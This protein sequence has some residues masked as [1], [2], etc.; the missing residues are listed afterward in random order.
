MFFGEFNYRKKCF[1]V[2][3]IFLWKG[4]GKI[5]SQKFTQDYSKNAKEATMIYLSNH[6]EDFDEVKWKRL[7]K[8][9]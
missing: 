6:N 3:K 2:N 1:Y 8:R 4:G 5:Y 9:K 7:Y